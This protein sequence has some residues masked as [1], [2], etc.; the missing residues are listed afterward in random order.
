MS[1]PLPASTA[2]AW[3]V[4]QPGRLTPPQGFWLLGSLVVSFLAASSAPSPLYGLY[5]ETFGFS[6][7]TL[8]LVF[9]V[10]AFA[11][12]GG[13]LV[14]GALSDYRGRRPVLLA[15]LL[16]ELGS[17]VLFLCADSV[18]WL[19][20][21]RLLQGLA[22]GIASAV[23]GA[24]LLDFQ[25]ERGALVNS[26]APMFGMAFGALGASALVQFAQ[27]PTRLVFEVALIIVG[28]QTWAAFYLPET[29]TRRPGAWRS[30]R[31]RLAVPEAARETLWLIAPLNTAQWAL[32]GFYLSLGPT[33]ARSVI[34]S[35]TPLLGGALI[36]TLV[37]SGAVGILWLRHRPAQVVRA[38]AAGGLCLGMLLTLAGIHF[39]VV[40]AFFL[41]TVVAG[42]GFG[43]GFNA[44]V[45]SLVP[46][47]QPHERGA[48]MA[49]FLVISYL[50]FSLPALAAGLAVGHVGIEAASLG[51]GL[52]LILIS[53]SAAWRMRKSL[54]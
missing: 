11:L 50:A 19:L 36:A 45:R 27:V 46:L 2:D 8:T 54:A 33:L 32:G 51:Y 38:A 14:L 1:V 7:L 18:A 41:G 30:L 6:A 47:A 39:H 12:L 13:L 25:R 52:A 23:L 5:R 20:A 28:L 43:A 15:A 53:G 26:V 16:L 40:T 35:A 4:Q 21:A 48:L 31:P 24:A 17:L 9:S 29:V 22:T 37:L 42:L 49:S 44:S 3:P 10:Y 34:G